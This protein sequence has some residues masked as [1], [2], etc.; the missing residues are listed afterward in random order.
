MRYFKAVEIEQKPFIFWNG[1]ANDIAEL[2]ELELF[3]DP[4]I[5]PED[6][7]PKLIYGV[8]P[9]K[10]VAGE[11]VAR[12][13]IEMNEYQSQWEVSQFLLE[14]SAL[15]TAINNGT[16]TYDSLTFPMDERSRVFYQ[17]FDRARGIG[18]VKCMTTDGALYTLSN[19]NIDAFLDEYFLQLRALS[20]P[21]VKYYVKH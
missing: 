7:I 12:T 9:L 17:A 2:A 1:V 8:C 10:I 20:Q 14:Q 16:F 19:A 18:D 6:S 5:L 11:L 4:L 13:T 21:L 3:E 15:Q